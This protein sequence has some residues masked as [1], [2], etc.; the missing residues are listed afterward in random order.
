MGDNDDNNNNSGEGPDKVFA[1]EAAT[2]ALGKL[3]ATKSRGGRITAAEIQQATGFED[4]RSFRRRIFTWAKHEK[5]VAFPVMNDGWRFGLAHE[6]VD[7]AEKR[8]KKALREEGRG[9]KALIDAP[10]AE[11]DAHQLRRTEFATQLAARRYAQA[12]ADHKATKHEFKLTDR[13]RVPL[14]TV[15]KKD[16]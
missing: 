4:W 11:L 14:L 5:L 9:L 2:V 3:L 1:R 8:R 7:F 13:E 16:T 12:A 10:R 15:K 6:H